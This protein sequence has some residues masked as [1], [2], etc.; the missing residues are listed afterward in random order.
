MSVLGQGT[1]NLV[2]S[3]ISNY[4]GDTSIGAGVSITYKMTGTTVSTWSP[5][6]Q[7]IPDMYTNFSGVSAFKGSYG[8]DEIES[9]GGL[10]EVGDTKFIVMNNQV[11]GVLSVDDMIYHSA[12]SDQSATTYQVKYLQNDPLRICYFIAGRAI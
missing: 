11:T 5:T 3:L 1:I 12:T 4:L 6:T 2:T 9:S 10:L 7:L 8:L